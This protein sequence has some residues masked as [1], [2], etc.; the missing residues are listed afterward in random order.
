MSQIF[1]DIDD[2]RALY[3]ALTRYNYFPNQRANVGELPPSLDTRQFTP[4]VLEALVALKADNE[5]RAG[6][7][8]L[9]EYKATRYNNVPRILALAHPMGYALLAKCIYDNWE[10]LKSVTENVNS[11]IKPEFHHSEKRLVVMNYEDVMVKLSRS[12]N[13]GF[14]KRF[15]A[16]ADIANC[17]N[18]IYSHAIPW[19]AVGIP[20]AKK[21]R[22]NK[23]WFNRLDTFQRK[24]KRNETQGVPIGSA[25]ST[26]VVEL[27][28]GRVDEYLR[29][30]GYEF[31]RYIDDYTCYCSTNDEAQTFIQDLS[32]QLSVYKLTLNLNKTSIE[33]LPAALED[34]WVLEL[35][36]ALPS[37]LAHAGENE[38]KL[39]ST[40]ALT[41]LNR[42]IGINKKTP[43]GS[44]LK[45][46]TSLI[47]YH[48]DEHA[49]MPLIEALLNL[50]WHYPVLLPLVDTLIKQSD[51]SPLI[52]NQ[53]LNDI[54]V[55]NASKFRSDG[56]SWPLHT[57]LTHGLVV[58]RET[59]V[60]VI[61]SGDCVAITLLFEMKSFNDLITAFAKDIVKVGDDYQK[62]NYW[63]LLYQ[64]YR[65]G[66]IKSPYDDGVFQCLKQYKV[67]FIPR[68]TKTDAED[69]CEEIKNALGINAFKGMFPLI[70]P[71]PT[72][73]QEKAEE[74]PLVF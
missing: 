68:D 27:I 63:L 19:A 72:S 60:K 23:L 12:H 51:L 7:Y 18:S 59:A 41:F 58:D 69:K 39:S 9:V 48:L 67:N 1:G 64:L 73:N 33:D 44:V 61:E 15:R 5:G 46:A 56:M 26:I 11:I 55:E 4:E 53:K 8:D 62:D 31:H 42:A 14:A 28:L 29:D 37:R 22:D 35:R 47:I 70:K 16:H 45:Y 25:T 49:P 21:Q 57:M 50:A 52:F 65:K 40:E 17:F 13:A 30:K 71:I 20:E 32:N 24:T 34:E 6:G 54:I 3:E 74:D 66:Q 36:G 43:D 10:D 38:P 2:K